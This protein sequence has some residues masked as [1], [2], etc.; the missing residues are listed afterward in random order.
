MMDFAN[1]FLYKLLPMRLY[2]MD[3]HSHVVEDARLAMCK[4]PF[5]QIRSQNTIMIIYRPLLS[6]T[7]MFHCNNVH[8]TCKFFLDIWTNIGSI[9]VDAY[10]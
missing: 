2:L 7:C 5:V 4:V 10:I 3:R 6:C 1:D 9:F 8:V